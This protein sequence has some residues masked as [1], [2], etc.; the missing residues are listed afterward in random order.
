MAEVF[1]AVAP[2]LAEPARHL[3]QQ[4]GAFG[5]LRKVVLEKAE[6]DPPVGQDGRRIVAMQ[7]Q[8]LFAH[9]GVGAGLGIA[10]AGDV[11]AF[12]EG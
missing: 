4:A 5:N 1:L 12:A 7:R 3:L 11:D 2:G 6:V 10:T 8:G 9:R